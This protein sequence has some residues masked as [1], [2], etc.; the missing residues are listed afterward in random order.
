MTDTKPSP[1]G[2]DDPAHRVEQRRAMKTGDLDADALVQEGVNL[3]R[4]AMWR[5][6]IDPLQRAVEINPEN[7]A[8]H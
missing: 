2:G 4:R 7:A 1:T 5:D 3:C 8:A 6:A